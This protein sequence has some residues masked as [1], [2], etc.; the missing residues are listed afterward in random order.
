MAGGFDGDD[1]DYENDSRRSSDNNNVERNSNFTFFQRTDSTPT[2][3][4]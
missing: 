3:E 2:T 4:L 1:S